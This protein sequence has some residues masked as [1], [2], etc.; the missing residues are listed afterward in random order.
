MNRLKIPRWEHFSHQADIGVRGYGD[1]LEM[2]FSQTAIAMMAVICNVENVK[3]L[4]RRTVYCN[5]ADPEILLTDWLNELVYLVAV[6]KMLFSRFDVTIRDT[7]LDA[8][9]WGEPIDVQRHQ[10]AVEVKG[11]TFTEL[12]VIQLPNSSWMAQCVIDV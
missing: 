3:P 8:T 5:A 7:T 10:P 1:T 9:I 12:R 4:I 11:A 2:A 6:D